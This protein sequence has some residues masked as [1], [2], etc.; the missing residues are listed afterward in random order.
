MVSEL[1]WLVGTTLGLLM[2]M[3][4]AKAK[5]FL[6][7]TTLFYFPGSVKSPAHNPQLL[8]MTSN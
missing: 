5:G 1:S 4:R 8:Y 6:C 7:F 2:R 3:Q